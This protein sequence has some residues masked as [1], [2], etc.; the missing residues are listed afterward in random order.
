MHKV[1]FVDQIEGGYQRY[2]YPTVPCIYD[3]DLYHTY[4]VFMISVLSLGGGYRGG[5]FRR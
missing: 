3:K 4:I 1:F 5:G 2:L